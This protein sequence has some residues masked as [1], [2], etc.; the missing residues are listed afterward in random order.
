MLL[1]RSAGPFGRIVIPARSALIF[2][3]NA[4]D[5]IALDATGISVDGALLA[6]AATCR[7]T[8]RVTITLHGS[9]PASKH[10]LDGMPAWSK[11]IAV[12]GTMELHGKLFHRTWTRLARGVQPGE[13]VVLLQHA[14]NWEASQQVLLTTT[15]LKDSRDWHQNEVVTVE[16]RL[17]TAELPAGVG[18]AIL[19]SAPA[20][21]EHAATDAYQA[22]VALLSRYIVIQGAASDSEPSDDLPVACDHSHWVLDSNSVPCPHTH[23]TGYGATV[24]ISGPT[25]IGRASAIELRRVGQT[26]VLGRYP[27]HLHLMG[28]VAAEQPGSALGATTEIH[29]ADLARSR[30]YLT[31]SSIHRSY[32]RCISLHGTHRA[33]VSQ[34]VAYDAIGHCYY[35]EDGVEEFN[36]LAHNLA[37]HVHFLSSPGRSDGQTCD[38]VAQSDTLL[39]PADVTASGFYI[40]NAHNVLIGNAASGGWAGFAFP[41]LPSP[42]KVHRDSHR[43]VT[44]SGR[45]L[46]RFQGNSAHSSGWWWRRAGMIYFGGKLWH[47]VDDP[48]DPLHGELTY[49]PCRTSPARGGETILKE[50]KVFLGRGVGVSHW[51][52]RPELTGFEAH[53]V[54]LAASILGAGW[55]DRMLVRCRTG[56]PLSLPCGDPSDCDAKRAKMAGSGFEWYDTNQAHIITNAT[57]RRCGARTSAHGDATVGCGD[58][59][60]GCSAPSSVWALLSH[61]DQHTPEYMQATSNI[62]YEA[63]GRRTRLRNFVSDGGAELNNGMQSTVSSRLIS[64]FDADGSTSSATGGVPLR[65][66][67]LIG[68]AVA[69]AGDWWRLDDACRYDADDAPLWLCEARGARQLGSINLQWLPEQQAALGVSECGNGQIGMLCT[70]HGYVRH[71]GTRFGSGYGSALPLTLNGEV[72]GALGGFGW[73]VRLS[74]GG[75]RELNISRMQVHHTTKLL[76]SISYPRSVTSVS[77]TAIAP[78]WCFKWESVTRACTTAFTRVSSISAV[79]R[80]LGNTYHL[81]QGILTLRLVQPPESSTG[82]PEWT[83]P[84]DPIAPFVRGGLTIPRFAWH[85]RLTIR[86]ECA[87][88]ASSPAFCEGAASDSEPPEPCADGTLQTAYDQCCEPHGGACISPDGEPSPPITS[89]D[90]PSPPPPPPPPPP[91]ECGGPPTSHTCVLS[92]EAVQQGAD[93]SCQYVWQPGCAQPS[94]TRLFCDGLSQL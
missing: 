90:A 93:C 72:T 12:S 29:A 82:T 28:S 61:S 52:S 40:T 77:V 60:S 18:G 13:R 85:S 78:P 46:L 7:L 48:T 83:V 10:A 9:R 8:T 56:A 88:S 55:I 33:I 21:Y 81:Q 27:Y 45:A 63:C 58:G 37:A 23:L 41:M 43:H 94:G 73:H 54:G 2:G 4:T 6:G 76:L 31:D 57:F 80:S 25:A 87:P 79:R 1:A 53:D 39:L 42:V 17:S 19:L 3:E 66:G 5:G 26:N 14:V 11:G 84:V 70:P 86:A 59:V 51:G 65:T 35:L 69:E 44:P 34:N 71:W 22:E 38:D 20:L 30:A 75:P 68:S 62:A 32:Y 47:R 24:Q 91:A 67:V 64:W 36:V 92:A 50:T 74:N 16:R 49:N 15:A 89:L